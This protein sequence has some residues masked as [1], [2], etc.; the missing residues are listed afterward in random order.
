MM[1][2]LYSLLLEIGEKPEA[3]L[4]ELSHEEAKVW[5]ARLKQQARQKA[6]SFSEPASFHELAVRS[7]DTSSDKELD[8]LGNQLSLKYFGRPCKVPI[9]WDKSLKNAAGYFSFDKRTHKPLRI[10]QSMWQYNQFGAQHVL[11]TLKHELAHYHLFMEGRPFHDDDEEFKQQ[12]LA[13][14]APLYALAM[15]EGYI[16]TCS[17]C[18]SLA[19]LEKKP[20]KKLMSRCCKSS[21]D[22]GAYILIFP[23]GQK[24]EVQ[25]E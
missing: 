6:K 11:G 4:S 22:F 2:M 14:G 15:K 13:I 9:E 8:W 10:V 12:C 7:I 5:I 17:V 1:K 16:T 19:G 18:G 25:K 23:N 21:L 20:R 3:G 24:V